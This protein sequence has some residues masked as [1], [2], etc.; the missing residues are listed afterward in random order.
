MNS[1]NLSTFFTVELLTKC[2]STQNLF[3]IQDPRKY[4]SYIGDMYENSLPQHL[5]HFKFLNVQFCRFPAKTLSIGGRV[6]LD[7]QQTN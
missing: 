2:N 6:K 1:H 4:R 3:I 5:W 7:L